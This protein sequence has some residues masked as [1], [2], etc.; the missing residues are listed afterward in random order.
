[1]AI[2]PDFPHS[3]Y[4]ILPPGARLDARQ[5]GFTHGGEA[6]LAWEQKQAKKHPGQVRKR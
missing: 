3:P 6:A 4:V 5:A 1:M 2:H